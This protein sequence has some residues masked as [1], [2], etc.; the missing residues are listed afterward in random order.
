MKNKLNK[1]RFW[2]IL[3]FLVSSV[4][5]QSGFI[6]ING[7]HFVYDGKP[8]YFV[9]AN[10]W[11]GCYLGSTGVTGNRERLLR[12]LDRLRDAGI[13][14]LRILGA[15]EASK[16][17][18]AITPAI[19][20]SPGVY[21][22]SLLVGLDY[23]LSEMNKR[24]LHAV[25]FLNNFW[26]WSGGMSQYETWF[27]VKGSVFYQNSL[28]NTDYREYIFDLVN[29]VNTVSGLRYYEDSAIMAWELA[30][31][32]RPAGSTA[33][34]D[35]WIDSTSYYIHSIDPNHLVTTGSEGT[36][37]SNGSESIFISAHQSLFIDY[38]TIHLWAYNWRW[39]DPMHPVTGAESYSSAL[40]KA[41]AYI[42][43]HIALARTLNKPLAMEEYGL[44]R[45]SSA[46]NPGSPTTY[47]DQYFNELLKLIY[48]SAAAGAPIAGSNFW[49]WGG[50]GRSPNSN[51]RWRPGDPF[52]CD[53]P[54][55]A[56]GLNSVY[57][58]DTSTIS[59]FKKYSIMMSNLEDSIDV[60]GRPVVKRFRLYQNYPNPFNPVTTI[61]YD[62]N[63]PINVQIKVYNTLGQ[64]V[65]ILVNDHQFAGHHVTTFDAGKLSSGIYFYHLI[66]G[67]HR[68]SKKMVV[69]K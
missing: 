8:Y 45:D 6:Q 36:I 50:E 3:I 51:F 11:Y 16:A 29:R 32:P 2:V 19:Q 62:L 59:I 57:D 61:E 34:F 43:E 10:F 40:V 30:N 64:C 53:P 23:L 38:A 27:P 15:S 49:G 44:Q 68:D 12:E 41:K 69:E 46:F 48:D 31:E 56:Q 54:M 65:A 52:V 35:N 26:T 33:I 13:N 67:S 58:T 66:A 39:Y 60:Y 42:Q 14:N 28:A 18:D 5:S 4:H 7:T 47:R 37:G 25:I 55:E 22:D 17:S 21:D 20:T 63:E 9:G 1:I 24:N